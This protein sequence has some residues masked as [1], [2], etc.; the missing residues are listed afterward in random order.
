MSVC[1]TA[2]LFF[3]KKSLLRCSGGTEVEWQDVNLE[4]VGSKLAVFTAVLILCTITSRNCLN[5]P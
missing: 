2:S 4:I 1:I 3:K 5:K